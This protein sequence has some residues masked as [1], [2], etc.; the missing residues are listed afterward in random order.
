M[1]STAILLLV[2][3]HPSCRAA[4]EP[5]VDP[6]TTEVLEWQAWREESLTSETG[7]LT[8]VGLHW[9]EPGDNPFG[10]DPELPVVL[11]ADGVPPRA[12]HEHVAAPQPVA[13]RHQHA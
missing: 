10:S 5:H 7:Y 11:S 9:L 1:R 4:P 3:A 8:L 12:G 13:Q 6:S 2:L